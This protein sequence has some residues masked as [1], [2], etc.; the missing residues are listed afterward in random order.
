MRALYVGDDRNFPYE[1]QE[2]PT[3]TTIKFLVWKSFIIVGEFHNHG[4][5]LKQ[6]LKNKSPAGEINQV[7]ENDKIDSIIGAGN[8]LADKYKDEF[9][10]IAT[11]WHSTTYDIDTNQ[12]VRKLVKKELNID[13][14]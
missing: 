12:S 8:L 9:D 14:L 2:L 4:D 1:K 10:V 11:G 5:L 13:E 7:E 6:Y 3:G